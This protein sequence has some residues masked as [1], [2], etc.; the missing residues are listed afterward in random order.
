MIR[1]N[2]NNAENNKY[3]TVEKALRE[4][5]SLSESDFLKQKRMA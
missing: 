5:N 4:A 2:N 3:D 1:Y